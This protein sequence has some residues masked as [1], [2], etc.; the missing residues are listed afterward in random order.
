MTPKLDSKMYLLNI[1][2][3]TKICGVSLSK[4]G[5]LIDHHES[6]EGNAHAANLAVFIDDL[7]KR[8]KLQ[9]RDLSAIAISEGPGSY[10]GLRIGT[11]TAKGL[12]YALDIPLIAIS[13]LQSMAA[14]ALSLYNQ[15]FNGIFRPLI[16]ARRMEVYSQAFD[17]ELNAIDEI[18][19]IVIDNESFVEELEKQ[20]IV[21]FGDGAEKCQESIQ[22]KNALFFDQAE[23]SALG[24]VQLS[25]Q[26]F[27]HK[28]FVDVAYFEPFYLKEFIA[29]VSV[30]KGLR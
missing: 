7:I 16:D 24:M 26:K 4:D 8:N 6:S 2:T 22:H 19:A 15:D 14:H 27:Q 13:T 21:F 20:V 5:Q 17:Q 9:Y 11:S 30:V 1:E 28:E 18:R 29:A 3:S 25:Y 12:C 23:A 10:T